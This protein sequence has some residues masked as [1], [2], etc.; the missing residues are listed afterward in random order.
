[1]QVGYAKPSPVGLERCLALAVI[2][3]PEDR[4]RVTH[5]HVGDDDDADRLACERAS[6]RCVHVPCDPMVGVEWAR[7]IDAINEV[8][9]AV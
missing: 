1:M 7:R 9:R 6:H 5:I 8:A 2:T 3:T 4:R